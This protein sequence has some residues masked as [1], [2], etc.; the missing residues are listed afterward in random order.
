MTYQQTVQTTATIEGIGLHSG[1]M[2]HLAIQ[3]APPNTGLV[4]CRVDLEEP[5]SIPVCLDNVDWSQLQ[6]AT[7]LRRGE[8][9]VKTCEH[10]LSAMMAAS[11]DNAFIMID[12]P[13]VPI[14]DGSAAPFW[15]MLQRA[16][17]KQQAVARKV[18]RIKKSFSFV[19]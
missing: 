6:L 12:G 15:E 3:P 17:V 2:I 4:F 10:L 16:G 9:E 1:E 7:T 11:I 19:R 14:L 5:V 18:L 13:E 8:A